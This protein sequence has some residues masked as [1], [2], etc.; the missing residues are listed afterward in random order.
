M[1]PKKFQNPYVNP[2]G[3]LA[4]KKSLEEGSFLL[5]PLKKFWNLLLVE[6]V[7]AGN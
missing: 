5:M 6:P 4:W 7:R 3:F 1:P 2:P